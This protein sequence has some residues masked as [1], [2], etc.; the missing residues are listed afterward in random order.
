[1]NKIYQHVGFVLNFTDTIDTIDTKSMWVVILVEFYFTV[2]SL[3]K[4]QPPAWFCVRRVNWVWP[5][6]VPNS[7]SLDGV[8]TRTAAEAAEAAQA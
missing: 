2:D 7:L 5:N 1:M 8:R 3:G 4:A 6:S